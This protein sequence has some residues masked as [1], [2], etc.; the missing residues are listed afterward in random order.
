[1]QGSFVFYYCLLFVLYKKL[2]I[3]CL[4]L[5]LVFVCVLFSLLF[6]MPLPCLLCLVIF[7]SFLVFVL[8]CVCR[9]LLELIRDV[10][11]LLGTQPELLFGRWL[12]KARAAAVADVGDAPFQEGLQKRAKVIVFCLCRRLL[13]CYSSCVFCYM[14]PVPCAYTYALRMSVRIFFLLV[15]R[16]RRRHCTK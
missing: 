15:R 1:M 5:F 10:D 14:S 4:F 13:L 9:T 6:L 7:V 2:C 16:K 12:N 11:A 8:V 3:C